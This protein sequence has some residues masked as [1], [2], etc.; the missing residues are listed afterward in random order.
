M[1][2]GT[3][4]PAR[5]CQLGSAA[6]PGNLLVV[7]RGSVPR[8]QG[9]CWELL[10]G[11]HCHARGAHKGLL[12]E[13]CRGAWEIAR[14]H[15]LESVMHL[16]TCRGSPPVGVSYRV[17]CPTG[18][19]WLGLLP[20]PGTRQGSLEGVCQ[21][22]LGPTGGHQQGC[23]KVPRQQLGLAGRDV[24]RHPGT[25]WV[26]PAGVCQGAREPAGDCWLGSTAMPGDLPVD[27]R[28]GVLPPLVASWRSSAGVC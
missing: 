9:T 4:G 21:G 23:T 3:Q 27:T 18:G 28:G 15:R 25:R 22:A 26:L 19:H 16:V 7:T 20:C 12:E 14:C 10:E 5:G 24:P 13:V 6:V 2:Q 1:C 11:V 17:R 8:H